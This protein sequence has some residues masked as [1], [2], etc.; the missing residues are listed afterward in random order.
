MNSNSICVDSSCENERISHT[1]GDHARP[2]R[3]ER[4]GDSQPMPTPWIGQQEV[5]QPAQDYI[6][7]MCVVHGVVDIGLAIATDLEARIT[8]GVKRYGQRLQ[9]QNGRSMLLDMYEETLDAY[10]YAFGAYLTNKTAANFQL[11][12]HAAELVIETKQQ[13]DGEKS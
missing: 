9:T 2:A 5:S 6:K 4:A 7:A 10:H 12:K 13:L 1:Y 3:F 8:L 11:F